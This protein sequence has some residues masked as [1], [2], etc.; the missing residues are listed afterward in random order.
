MDIK[1]F[2]VE[3]L[4]AFHG[5]I[6]DGVH[7]VELTEEYIKTLF[8]GLVNPE[9]KIHYEKVKSF[10]DRIVSVKIPYI[11][12]YNTE[13]SIYKNKF[14]EKIQSKFLNGVLENFAKIIIATR[15]EKD[16][17]AL[18]KWLI[19]PEMYSNYI[20][21]NL[22]LLKMQVYI[23]KLPEW[24]KEDDIKRFDRKIRK[25]IIEFSEQEGQKGIS[26]RK[27]LAVFSD[28]I[29]K[30]ENSERLITMEDVKEYFTNKKDELEID[31]PSDFIDKLIDLYDYDVLQQVKD[32]LYFYNEK[33]IT[34]EILNYLFAINFEIGD[35]KKN[36]LTNE[37]IEITEDF[38]SNFEIRILGNN[39]TLSVRKN[40]RNEVLNEYVTQTLS[41]EIRVNNKKVTETKQFKN[42]FDKYTRNLKENVLAP[43]LNNDNSRRAILDYGTTAFYTYDERIKRDVSQ[44]INNLVNKYHYSEIGAKQ[45]S[46]YV[47]DKK[48]DYKY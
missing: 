36:D 12:D 38:L 28:F 29:S 47:L 18:K 31:L 9:D 46:V 27:S 44:L 11:L 34:N 33:H 2:N 21:K 40:F 37:E 23:G 24:L 17:P 20:D 32:S 10:Q 26:G 4:K 8:L 43:Y 41:Q 7:K 6:S 16:A 14:G 45:V 25:E 42:L 48:I 13:F 30:Y 5:I 15:L 19:K 22:L 39:A 1:E 35:V 3:R